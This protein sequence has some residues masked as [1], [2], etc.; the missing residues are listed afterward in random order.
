VKDRVELNLNDTANDLW[1]RRQEERRQAERRREREEEERAAS[2]NVSWTNNKFL[3]GAALLL[4]GSALAWWSAVNLTSYEVR[5]QGTRVEK[6]EARLDRLEPQVV[7]INEQLRQIREA[8][9]R[10]RA[11]RRE[12]S[13]ELKALLRRSR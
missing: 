6:A 12:E 13:A 3:A 11:E 4:A 8:M 10:D 7:V 5:H 2:G 1:D 9:D